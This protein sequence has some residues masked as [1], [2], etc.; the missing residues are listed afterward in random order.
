MEDKKGKTRERRRPLSRMTG[1]ARV[2][3]LTAVTAVVGILVYMTFVAHLQPLGSVFTIPLWGM[4]TLF[5]LDEIAV[6]HLKFKRDAYS[7]SL[8]EIPLVLGLFFASPTSLVVGQVIGAALALSIVRR[9]SLIKM[10]FNVSHYFLEACVACV[11]FFALVQP[12][13]SIGPAVWGV[14]F[15]A[16]FVPSFMSISMVVFAISLSEGAFQWDT[17]PKGLTYGAVGTLTNTSLALLGVTVINFA[18]EAAVLLVVP[19]ALLFFAYRAYMSQMDQRES[20]EF[21]Y[22]STRMA[23]VQLEAESAVKAL[24]TQTREM[25][26]AEVAQLLLFSD[27]EEG[28]GFRTGIGPGDLRVTGKRIELDPREGVWARVAAEG[29]ALLIPRPIT[30]PRLKKHFA[31]RGIHRDAMV[32]PMFGDEKVIGTI[33]VGDRLGDVS[34]FDQEDLKLFETLANHASVT[35]E[36]ARLVDRLRDSLAH[37]T[38][39]NRLKDDFVAAVSHELRTPLT[40]IQGYV[41]TLL[42]PGVEFTAEQRQGFLEAVDR[43]SQ[44]LRNLI[45]DLLVVSR[46]EGTPVVP[47]SAQ[48]SLPK[49]MDSVIGELG[50]RTATHDLHVEGLERLPFVESDEG[51][52]HQ[53]LSNLIDNACKYSPEESTVRVLARREG[54]GIAISVVDE[55]PGI[56]VESQDRVFD[57]FY[58][59]DQSS[60]RPAGGTGLGLYIC[61][62]LAEALEGR[63]WLEETGPEGSTFSLWIPLVLP[64]PARAVPQPAPIG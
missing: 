54:E 34:T 35:L 23:Q 10:C 63:V 5:F 3:L 31:E 52:L 41:K 15:L 11:L 44:R 55:G 64:A 38:E 28:V 40:S 14:T 53:I 17:L 16:T 25:F 26:R 22:E 27:E 59:V 39:M 2:W 46:L 37:M 58:Q 62:R 33:M 7:F 20:V 36:N 29:E 47:V 49:L 56:P 45:E 24:L 51:K 19:G 60:T 13:T 12:G 1:A 4:A 18:P 9:Q 21:L 30:N 42:R 57:R 43:Q 32:A 6:V 61:R 50:H 8:A 48:V